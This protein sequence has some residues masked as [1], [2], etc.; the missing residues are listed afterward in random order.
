MCFFVLFWFPL[1][2]TGAMVMHLVQIW[3]GCN[4]FNYACFNVYIS[5]LQSSFASFGFL[6]SYFEQKMKIIIILNWVV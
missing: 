5:F 6:P 4:K 1:V 2:N 3:I